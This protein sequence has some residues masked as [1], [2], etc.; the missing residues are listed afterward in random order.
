[1]DVEGAP[2]C[3]PDGHLL[4]FGR[5]GFMVTLWEA[6]P[7]FRGNAFRMYN[8]GLHHVAFAAPSRGAVDTLHERLIAMGAEILDPPRE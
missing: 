6:S 5:N 8:V 3:D 7:R 4:V 2:H 1:M